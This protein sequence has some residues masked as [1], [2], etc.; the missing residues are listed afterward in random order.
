VVIGAHYDTCAN[1][2]AD[3]NASG[4]AGILELARLFEKE[5]KRRNIQFVAFVTVILYP[6]YIGFSEKKANFP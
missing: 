5:K 6:K 4:I 2:G 3:D 1:P